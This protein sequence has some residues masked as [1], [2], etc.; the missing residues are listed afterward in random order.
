[1]IPFSG[2]TGKGELFI[3]EDKTLRVPLRG[4]NRDFWV[5]S[6]RIIPCGGTVVG[7]R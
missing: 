1:M 5:Q 7:R 2:K 4:M 6:G 3:G